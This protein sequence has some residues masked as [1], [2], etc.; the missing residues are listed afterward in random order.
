MSQGYSRKKLQN[1]KQ[2]G[3]TCLGS[4][5]MLPYRPLQKAYNVNG[6]LRPTT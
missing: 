6:G 1:K 5:S 4:D 2:M 3:Q